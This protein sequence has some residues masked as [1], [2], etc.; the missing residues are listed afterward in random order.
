MT[1]TPHQGATL[2]LPHDLTASAYVEFD[3]EGAALTLGRQIHAWKDDEITEWAESRVV[4]RGT[5]HELAALAYAISHAVAVLD[6]AEEAVRLDGAA[7][8]PE[9][10]AAAVAGS[11]AE[12]GESLVEGEDVIDQNE[13]GEDCHARCCEP[14]V[15][16][17]PI[18]GRGPH[19]RVSGSEVAEIAEAEDP[20]DDEICWLPGNCRRHGV[21]M[22]PVDGPAVQTALVDDCGGRGRHTWIYPI[23]EYDR[24]EGKPQADTWFWSIG[25]R[26]IA[27]VGDAER[28][29]WFGVGVGREVPD[30]T[31]D[32]WAYP[33]DKMP[34]SGTLLWADADG[35][36]HTDAIP[37]PVN[38]AGWKV[39]TQLT[40]MVDLE[41]DGSPAG[42][43]GD[44][45]LDTDFIIG[46]T[47]PEGK[48]YE[49]NDLGDRETAVFEAVKGGQIP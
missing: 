14:P 42:I 40:A 10:V 21:R 18:W 2:V 38:C 8:H 13:A 32:V 34:P 45:F 30:D 28:D 43:N 39:D 49:L 12:C 25:D 29:T 15:T 19:H 3:G 6:G 20:A 47:D 11:C 44:L 23:A 31:P 36:E 24:P 16:D 1:D 33:I 26:W 5:P 7:F 17:H 27:V 48:F 9:V 46:L 35:T 37:G 4:I 22:G 41:A